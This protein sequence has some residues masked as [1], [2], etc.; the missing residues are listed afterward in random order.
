MRTELK[1]SCAALY[2]QHDG[3]RTYHMIQRIR[4]P[5]LIWHVT[6][7]G[8]YAGSAIF[9]TN[10]QP[11]MSG[12]V[13]DMPIWD[14]RFSRAFNACPGDTIKIDVGKVWVSRYGWVM[15]LKDLIHDHGSL[16]WLR[17]GF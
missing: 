14:Q 16:P 7:P 12:I 13:A 8:E 3:F 17:Y 1:H 9:Q 15:Y 6:V 11:G 2:R 10:P 5:K 4:E